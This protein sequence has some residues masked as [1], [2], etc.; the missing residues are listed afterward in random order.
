MRAHFSSVSWV[1]AFLFLFFKPISGFSSEQVYQ[2]V[3]AESQ[4][5]VIDASFIK[6]LKIEAKKYAHPGE[7]RVTPE[8][9]ETLLKIESEF[10]SLFSEDAKASYQELV[11]E[12]GAK[13]KHPIRLP[14]QTQPFW[15]LQEGEWVNY[16]S[17]A[18]L[19]REAGI[20]II[21]AGLTGASAAYHAF[22][23]S[24]EVREGR[25]SVVVLE[26]GQPGSGASGH[27][28]GNFQLLSESYTG[29]AY[30]GLIQERFKI[31]SARYP[32]RDDAVLREKAK[33]Q[34]E[35]IVRF[36][37]ANFERFVNLVEREKIECDFSRSGWLRTCASQEEE[38]SMLADTAWLAEMNV[39]P[40]MEVWSSEKM[41]AELH[42]KSPFRGRF[43]LGNGNY[44]PYKYLT[45]VFR[46]LLK[47]GL[48]LYTGVK[49]SRVES[50][51]PGRVRVETPIGVI[52][53]EKVIVA[54]NAF[55][56]QLFP[57]FNMIHTVP[58]QIMNL[59]HIEDPL[60]GA[61]V[62]ERGGDIYYNFP[63]SQQYVDASGTRRGMLHYGLDY[64]FGVEDPTRLPIST[65]YL[66]EMLAQTSER[67][68]GTEGQP[69]SR[70]WTGPMAFTDDRTPLIGFM[71][72]AENPKEENKDIVM[73][74]AF[75]GYGGSFCAQAGYAAAHAVFSGEIDSVAPQKVFSPLRYFNP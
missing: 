45:G 59:E 4:K 63:R 2:L 9:Q 19:P 1:F 49:V 32:G 16:R 61:T 26:A 24:D 55:T 38:A 74:V 75:Q 54:T 3:Q 65:E 22:A 47:K 71:P 50:E 66:E 28:G 13:M 31:L 18:E 42:V 72:L 20:V 17:T 56:P 70:M 12:L 41:E 52:Y 68:P 30:E 33:E 64:D 21:G 7:G 6:N 69:P 36:S 10:Y 39:K 27:N 25:K 48:K 37:E 35:A 57:Q 14:A 43:A 40:K 44:H 60:Q 34:A 67:F 8:L 46:L 15:L 51:A 11:A 73:A 29:H 5:G 58:S 23:L 53:A 62:T